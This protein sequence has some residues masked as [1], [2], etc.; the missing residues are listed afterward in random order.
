M[1]KDLNLTFEVLSVPFVIASMKPFLL[2]S[3]SKINSYIIMSIDSKIFEYL[4]F[5]DS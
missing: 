5:F 2:S 1:G 3:I 4:I